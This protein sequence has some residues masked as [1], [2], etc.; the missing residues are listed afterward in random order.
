MLPRSERGKHDDREVDGRS[1]S[2][3]APFAGELQTNTAAPLD[4]FQNP[5]NPTNLSQR[6]YSELSRNGVV[7]WTWMISP[8]LLLTQ[9]GNWTRSEFTAVNTSKGF[10]PSTLGGPF[11]HGQIVAFENQRAGGGDVFPQINVT[12][13]SPLGPPSIG[14]D[15]LEIPSSY[16]YQAGLSKLVGRHTIKGGFSVGHTPVR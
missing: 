8:T 2:P 10:D 9:S 12:G 15:Y 7:N 14:Y 1:D 5:A 13:Y 6:D 16:V 11:S 4:F 3:H